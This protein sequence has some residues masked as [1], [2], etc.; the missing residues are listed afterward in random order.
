MVPA[1]GGAQGRDIRLRVPCEALKERGRRTECQSGTLGG[2]SDGACPHCGVYF[3]RR[4]ATTQKAIGVPSSP[5]RD[6][7]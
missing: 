7:R 5:P 6:Y 1:M 4:D 3:R 2:Q